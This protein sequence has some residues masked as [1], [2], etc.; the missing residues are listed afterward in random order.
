MEFKP[1]IP[2]AALERRLTE[3][4]N[5]LEHGRRTDIFRTL[6]RLVPTFRDPEEVNRAALSRLAEADGAAEEDEEEA[7]PFEEKALQHIG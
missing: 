6:H 4:S 2:E 1:I 3:L 7:C 5:V